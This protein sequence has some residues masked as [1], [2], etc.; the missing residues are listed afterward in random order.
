MNTYPQFYFLIKFLLKVELVT[1]HFNL[2]MVYTCYHLNQ[3]RV[4]IQDL[5]EF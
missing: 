1:F 2:F 4:M 5:L 3:D